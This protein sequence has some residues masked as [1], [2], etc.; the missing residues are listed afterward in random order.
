MGVRHTSPII[1]ELVNRIRISY[2]GR[3]VFGLGVLREDWAATFQAFA[4]ADF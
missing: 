1:V 4:E 2:K 3:F